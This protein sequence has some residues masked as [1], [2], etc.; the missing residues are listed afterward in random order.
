MKLA[1]ASATDQGLVRSN[2]ED[3]FLIDD[4][5]A[6]FAVAD[7]M[8]GHRGGEVAS[9]TAIEA[10]RAAI[11][12]GTPLHDAITRANTAVLTRAAGDDELTGM[13]TTMTA[14]IAIGGHQLL[15]GH[16]GDSRA[17]MLHE[18]TLRRATDDHSLVEEL[19]REGRLTPEQAEAHPQRA[20]VTRALGVDDP[21]DVDLY[22]LDVETGDRVVLCS[23]GLTTMVRE[24]DIERL[25][26][27]EPDPQ[28]L[29]E[30]LV[31]A[32]N[33]AGGEDNI[34]VVVV[35]VLE[36]DPPL[37]HDPTTLVAAPDSPVSRSAVIPPPEPPAP[38][39]PRPKGSRSRA[40]RG[41]ILVVLP[42]L[43]IVGIAA[44]ALGWYA[45]SSYF[46]GASG[47]EVVI[48]KGVPGGVLGW[49]PTVDERTGLSVATLPAVDR[50]RVTTNS[51]R[52]SLA[53]A[54][55]YVGRLRASVAATSTTTTTRPKRTT[56]TTRPRRTTTTRPAGVTATTIAKAGA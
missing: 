23:D 16:V 15:I 37:A 4:Q 24:R 39:Q 36:V 11:A 6:L 21:V 30:A 7:G 50:D 43:L 31:A 3:A 32:A 19:V 27:A 34:T 18:G 56:T 14:V 52:G 1:A 38:R 29:A 42:L 10:L 54:E 49:N 2:N 25:A 8:G 13:G 46:V 26:R 9:R 53:T 47:N 33:A 35:D 5:R 51:S 40:V 28:R 17:Y 41:V 48:Y 45:R 44:G 55:A 20:I 22:T 12:N